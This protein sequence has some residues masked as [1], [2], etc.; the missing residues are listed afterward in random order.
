MSRKKKCLHVWKPLI[1]I[2]P[3]DYLRQCQFCELIVFRNKW[4]EFNEAWRRNY[5]S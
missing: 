2:S 4:E 3:L 1:E 5:E